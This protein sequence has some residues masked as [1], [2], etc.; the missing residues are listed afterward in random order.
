MTLIQNMNKYQAL[1][2]LSFVYRSWRISTFPATC[3]TFGN[4]VALACNEAFAIMYVL[5]FSFIVYDL[6]CEKKNE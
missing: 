1:I 4:E 3:S 2:F 5:F 6:I